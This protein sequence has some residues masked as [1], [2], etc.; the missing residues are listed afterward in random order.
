M[1]SVLGDKLFVETWTA[2]QSF[3][4]HKYNWGQK[5]FHFSRYFRCR[6]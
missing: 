4:R 3:P 6:S 1:S 2:L 5:M